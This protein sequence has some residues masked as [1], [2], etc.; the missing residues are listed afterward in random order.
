VGLNLFAVC[1]TSRIPLQQVVK[2]CVPFFLADA[3][4]LLA[5][6]FFPSLATWLP[7]MLVKSV[8]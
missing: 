5:V 4:V 6:I 3:I 8:F 2:G 7:D 1:G